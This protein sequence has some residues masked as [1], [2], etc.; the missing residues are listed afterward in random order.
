MPLNPKGEF[1]PELGNEF[2]VSEAAKWA[3]TP[4]LDEA[5]KHAATVFAGI[6]AL[7]PIKFMSDDVLIQEYP[8]KGKLLF[9]FQCRILG[10]EHYCHYTYDIPPETAAQL[11]LM[12][13]W[14]DIK[15]TQH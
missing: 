9:L 12:G 3:Q 6:G 15:P 14:G 1:I 13:M 10:T 7:H 5:A 4:F 2:V 11:S 8:S